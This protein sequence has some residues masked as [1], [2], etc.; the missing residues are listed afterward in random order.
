MF[1]VAGPLEVY[2]TNRVHWLHSIIRKTALVLELHI[3]HIMQ[4]LSH[5]SR[6]ADQNQALGCIDSLSC[7][8][9]TL[10]CHIS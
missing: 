10:T 9:S 3:L 1:T 8:L 6:N 7:N 4:L 5:L 2:L